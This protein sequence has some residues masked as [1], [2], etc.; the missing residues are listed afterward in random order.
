MN[1]TIRKITR[2]NRTI[3]PKCRMRKL[4]PI[5]FTKDFIMKNAMTDEIFICDNC[6]KTFNLT[7]RSK[8]VRTFVESV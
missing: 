4:F 6:H 8:G 3:C 5:I 7:E 2:E 1:T